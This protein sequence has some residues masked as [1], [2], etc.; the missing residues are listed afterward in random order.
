[1]VLPQPNQCFSHLISHKSVL[2]TLKGWSALAVI[3]STIAGCSPQTT[4]EEIVSNGNCSVENQQ[5]SCDLKKPHVASPDWREQIIYFL[6][7]DRFSDGVPENNDQGQGEYGPKKESHFNG[8]DIPGIS[9]KLDYIQGLGATS[10]W[11]TP[12]VAN[13]WWSNASSFGG[14][15]GY[16]ARDFTKID[17]HFGTL[18]DYKALSR[19]LHAKGMYLIQD[20][21]INHTGPFFGYEG[22]Y[23]PED[24]A[25]NF[26]LFEKEFQ[27]APEQPPFH[28]INRLDLQHQQADIYNW[29]PSITD[30]NDDTQRLTY[31]LANLADINT[32]H[33]EVLKTF[34]EVYKYWIKE[35]GVDAYRVDTAKF[36]EHEFWQRFFHDPDGINA[37][38][39]ELGKNHF[40]SFGEVFEFSSTYLND[41]EQKVQRYYGT[42]Q[43]P[44]FNSVLG[45]PLYLELEKVFAEGKPTKQLEYRLAQHMDYGDPFTVV[46]F[47]D[48]HDVKR[49]LAV[50]SLASFKQALG[51]I[52][53][54]PGIPAIYQGTEQAMKE[55]RQTMFAGGYM[56][57]EDHFSTESEMYQFISR[58]SKVRLANKALTHGDLALLKSNEFGPGVLAFRREYQGNSILVILNSASHSVLLSDL[59]SGFEIGQHLEVLFSEGEIDGKSKA[60]LVGAGGR[61]DMELPA[62]SMLFLTST[63]ES[64]SSEQLEANAKKDDI[65]IEL[66]EQIEGETFNSDIQISGTIT[67]GNTQLLVVLNGDLDSADRILADADGRFSF[68]LPVKNWG[69]NRYG[70]EVYAPKYGVVSDRQVFTTLVTQAELVGNLIDPVDDAKGP[71]GN[72]IRPQHDKADQQ[73]EI[74]GVQAKSA[75]ANLEL[76]LN[77][78]QISDIWGPANGFDNVSFS[79]YLHI[80]GKEGGTELPYINAVMPQGLTWSFGHILYGWGNYMFEP[81]DEETKER[82]S[83]VGLAPTIKTIKEENLIRILYQGEQFGVTDWSNIKIYISTW[84]MTG[85][86]TFRELSQEASGWSFGG[87]N[88][89]GPKVMDDILLSLKPFG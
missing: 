1:M 52:F 67:E 43:N 9:A 41:G 65:T 81:N 27:R 60:P 17:E 88:P 66:D 74:I 78:Q 87:A 19:N 37:F 72:Y 12:P 79:I 63:P 89:N 33:P 46:N 83:K 18:E 23:H 42:E 57:E 58:L 20:I 10:V 24:T 11:I 62:N 36:V 59:A 2:K 16:W 71:N 8:G 49:F 84:D 64:V 69:E 25:K 51:V 55:T 22:G 30:F 48:N 53:A 31:Q 73:T 82:G 3:G 50:G 21:V 44:E 85:E 54:I 4:P 80:P 15:H 34:K 28:Q 47:V 68:N 39:R 40:L 45:F 86:G 29:T 38:A 75:G 13:L 77:M 14:Y 35:V 70:L 32:R 26:V 61:I 76:T 5:E 56:S 7:I 6:M